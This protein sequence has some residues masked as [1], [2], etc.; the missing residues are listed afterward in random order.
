MSR[1]RTLNTESSAAHISGVV[2]PPGP[3]KI[4]VSIPLSI[5]GNVTRPASVFSAML[6]S[7]LK[8]QLLHNDGVRFFED[9]ITTGY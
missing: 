5:E 3:S 8:Y 9:E 6:R 1:E 2:L 4:K 7:L